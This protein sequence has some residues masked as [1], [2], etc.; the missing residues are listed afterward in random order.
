VKLAI[1]GNLDNVP[2]VG[3]IGLYRVLQEAL[4][5]AAR[6]AGGSE[7]EVRLA[8]DDDEIRLE[9]LDR[10]RGFDRSA[11]RPE[12]LGLAGMR[13]RAELLGGRFSIEPRR[14]GPGTRVA[15]AIPRSEGML[16]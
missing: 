6:H 5:N 8:S 2:V 3:K 1:S 7:I 16:A 14:D 10:G 13:E 11:V 12:A 9:V 4:S 15:F